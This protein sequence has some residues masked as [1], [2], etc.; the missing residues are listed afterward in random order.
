[1]TSDDILVG[2]DVEGAGAGLAVIRRSLVSYAMESRDTFITV[3]SGGV[4]STALGMYSNLF[5]FIGLTY[6]KSMN[7]F[8]K[9]PIRCCY[10]H[11]L[12]Y[13]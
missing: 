8:F 2:R 11:F 13:K 9:G 12:T 3:E 7:P 4:V 1:M 6:S 5:R 10:I